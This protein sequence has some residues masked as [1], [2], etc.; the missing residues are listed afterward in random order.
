VTQTLSGH[1][2]RTVTYLFFCYK[3]HGR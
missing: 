2:R 1:R 3:G